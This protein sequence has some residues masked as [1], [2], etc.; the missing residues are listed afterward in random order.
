MADPTS[1]R[2]AV[3]PERCIGAGQCEMLEPDT[4]YVDDDSAVA[5]V[6]GAGLLTS[7]RA[8]VL[9]DRCPS[10]AISIVAGDRPF[11]PEQG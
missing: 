4:F 5:S 7:E 2:L 9:I 8:A 10:G 3:D 11:E 6:T 1:V